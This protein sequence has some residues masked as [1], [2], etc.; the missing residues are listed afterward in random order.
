MVRTFLNSFIKGLVL[1]GA[2]VGL[3]SRNNLAVGHV[4]MIEEHL[5]FVEF[6]HLGVVVAYLKL[7]VV[8]GKWVHIIFINLALVRQSL[9][10]LYSTINSLFLNHLF[11][12]NFLILLLNCFW[13]NFGGDIF[14]FK[15]VFNRFYLN[16]KVLHILWLHSFI[17]WL[18]EFLSEL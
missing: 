2:E 3:C 7:I 15:T 6:H 8:V 4:L 12:F 13:F 10:L 16:L 5:I 11:D 1:H 18:M 14:N 9:R 17:C